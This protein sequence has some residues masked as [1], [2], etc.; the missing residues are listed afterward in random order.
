MVTIPEVAPLA[1]RK[2]ILIEKSDLLRARLRHDCSPLRRPAQLLD[3]GYGVVRR[4]R[5]GLAIAIPLVGFLL[6]KRQVRGSLK[7]ALALLS[8]IKTA[9]KALRGRSRGRRLR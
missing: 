8:F 6:S 3:R 2:Q 7:K 1:A 4:F 5:P 9:Q